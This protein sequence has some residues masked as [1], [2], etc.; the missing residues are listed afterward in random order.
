VSV[1]WRVGVSACGPAGVS[2][3]WDLKRALAFDTDALGGKEMQT[4]LVEFL[5][6]CICSGQEF[7]WTLEG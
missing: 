7:C 5:M 2:V 4:V 3:G 1:S 6:N